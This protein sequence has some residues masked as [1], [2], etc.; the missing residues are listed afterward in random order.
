MDP[1]TAWL[2]GLGGMLLVFLY[3]HYRTGDLR[4]SFM[5]SLIWGKITAGVYWVLGLDYPLFTIYK[6]YEGY[7]YYPIATVTA[8]MAILF[9]LFATNI[10]VY[11]WPELKK[12]LGGGPL[13]GLPRGPR[14]RRK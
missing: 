6:Y 5:I 3:F 12:E 11:A 4:Y 1:R 13:P 7:G 10:I 2:Y 14:P 8:N 9:L